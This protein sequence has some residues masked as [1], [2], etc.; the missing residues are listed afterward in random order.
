MAK[1]AAQ[2]AAKYQRGVQAAGPDYAAGVQNPKKDWAQQMTAAQPRMVAGLQKAIAN[3]DILKG[4]QKSG[5]SQNWQQKAAT[6]GARNYSASAA[7]AGQA[8][9]NVAQKIVD[10]GQAASNAASGLPNATR[11]QREARAIAAMRA[12]SKAHGKS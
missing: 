7:D 1:T 5:G 3:G 6:K 4:V 9:S 12:I 10:A 2:I 8:Y 11:E